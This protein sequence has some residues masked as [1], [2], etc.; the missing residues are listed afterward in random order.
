MESRDGGRRGGGWGPC[1]A[2]AHS[3]SSPAAPLTASTS[4]SNVGP[5][6]QARRLRPAGSGP[7]A[8]D[9]VACAGGHVHR[10]EGRGEGR[11]TRGA[12]RGAGNAVGTGR[13]SRGRGG[14]DWR[15]GRETIL[16]RRRRCIVGRIPPHVLSAGAGLAN[17]AASRRT[18]PRPSTWPQSSAAS[19]LSGCCSARG[20]TSTGQSRCVCLCVVL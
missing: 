11:G 2:H 12:R 19:R 10:G 17:L 18:G 7:P 5:P 4:D 16:N 9:G 14:G 20:P 1:W 15:R 3:P 8:R 13:W 6:A